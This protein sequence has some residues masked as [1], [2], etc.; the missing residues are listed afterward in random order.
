MSYDDETEAFEQY[1][2]A[3]PNNCVFLV[4]TFDTLEGVRRAIAVGKSLRKRGHEIV[5]IRLDSG[6]LAWLSIEARRLL[7]AAGFPDAAIVAS[8]DLDERL[9]TSLKQQGARISVWGV[10]TK[11]ATAYDQPALG[12][13]YKLAAIRRPGESWRYRV[14][15]SEQSVK[16]STPGI[17]QV[18]RYLA[19]GRFACDVIYDEERPLGEIP[20]L[21]DPKDPTRRRRPPQGSVGEDLLQPVFRGG[22]QVSRVG[23]LPAARARCADQLNRLYE[24]CLRLDNP[25]EYP[26]GLEA[27]LHDLKTELILQA[28]VVD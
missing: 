28:R 21:V 14:K 22:E 20:L 24:G 19:S 8:N 11:L 15:L 16:V 3:M 5:G 6:D 1:A 17:L 26:V 12:G 9:I 7:D 27:S 10:G 25:H 2:E 13:V 23:E 4:D 18:R